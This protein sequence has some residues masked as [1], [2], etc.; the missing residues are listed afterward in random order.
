MN[1]SQTAQ[2]LTKIAAFDRRTIGEADVL[3]W[4]DVLEPMPF[5]DCMLAVTAHFTESRDWCMPSDIVG[6]VKKIRTDR[7]KIAGQIRPNDTDGDQAAYLTEIR[8]LT[9]EVAA[10][11]ITPAELTDYE[12]SGLSLAD[13]RAG[14]PRKV[15]V[16]RNVNAPR[17]PRYV[18]P[19]C[20]GETAEVE[21][22]M[23]A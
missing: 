18:K 19:E 12:D 16:Y 3:A 8:A 10:G 20:W 17:P 13:W 22:P 1:R 9:A 2:V 11:R 23:T 15:L 5:Q 7:L 6:R 4:H 14:K 21:P